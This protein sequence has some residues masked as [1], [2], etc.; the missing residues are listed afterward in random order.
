MRVPGAG[1][2][3]ITTAMTMEA[4]IYKPDTSA[5]VPIVEYSTGSNYGPHLWNYDDGTKLYVNFVDTGGGGA[6]LMS[7]GGVIAAGQWYHVVATYDGNTVTLY[8]NGAQVAQ[9]ALG[10]HTLSTNM[11]LY[12]GT[13]AQ[14]GEV[15]SGRIDDVALYSRALSATEVQL[16][17]TSGWR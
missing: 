13:R 16:H 2:L 8:V 12:I 7:S 1:S 15:F 6:S 11:A 14:S 9:G 5:Q 3:N 4:W 17:Y 10:A